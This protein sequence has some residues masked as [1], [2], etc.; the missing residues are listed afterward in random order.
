VAG[1]LA[2]VLGSRAGV[3]FGPYSYTAALQP[4]MLGVPLVMA[5]AWLIVLG[6]VKAWFTR[7]DRL[8]WGQVPVGALWVTSMDLIIDP[9][10]TTA[11][12]YWR[13]H[14]DGHYMGVPLSNF[15][16]WLIVSALL[17]VSG[18]RVQLRGTAQGW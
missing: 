14:A 9:V 18:T 16:G 11:L 2:E 5:C 4:Q 13:W 1:F 7:F 17:L 8:G 6:Y 3:P 10:A 15:A 12:G